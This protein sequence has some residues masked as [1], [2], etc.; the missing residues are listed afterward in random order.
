MELHLY[1]YIYYFLYIVFYLI[2][3]IKN[4]VSIFRTNNN[5]ELCEKIITENNIDALFIQQEIIFKILVKNNLT[6]LDDIKNKIVERLR[7]EPE[8]KREYL[9]DFF[10]KYYGQNFKDENKTL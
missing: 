3:V 8:E 9:S 1:I 10:S 4:I 2:S 7:D 6:D 5:L